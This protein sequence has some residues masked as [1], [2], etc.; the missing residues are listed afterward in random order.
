M[1][2]STSHSGT[3]FVDEREFE[4]LYRECSNWNRWGAQD[5]RGT[6]NFVT[7]DVTARAAAR[8]TSGVTVSCAHVLDTAVASDNPKPV[9]H[10]MTR[11]PWPDRTGWGNTEFA[12]DAIEVHCHGDAHSH[13]DAL[14]HVGYRGKLYNGWPSTSVTERGARF[15]GLEHLADGIVSRGVLL[16]IPRLRGVEWLAPGETVD[17]AELTRA[18]EAEGVELKSGDVLLV[19]TGHAR[20]RAVEG[21]WNAAD[22]K[23]GLHPRAML[24]VKQQQVAAVGFDGDGDAQPHPCGAITAPIHVLGINSMGLTFFDALNLDA[25]AEQCAAVYTW[26]F[27]F[28]ASPL[29]IVGATG[30]VVNPT[31]IF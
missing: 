18:A 5:Q 8:V 26:E 27:L 10:R 13:V 17:T 6:L 22:E 1:S 25:L 24:W 9:A 19:R 16:D 3:W 4:E 7:P 29:A 11:L 15:G 12:A 21:P 23:A 20:R 2:D 31:A 28:V 30:S 14:C